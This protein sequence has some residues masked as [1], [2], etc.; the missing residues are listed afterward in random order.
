MLTEKVFIIN[1]LNP[2]MTEADII[3]K[4]VHWFAEQMKGLMTAGY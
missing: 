3:Q 4:P 1:A 2:F